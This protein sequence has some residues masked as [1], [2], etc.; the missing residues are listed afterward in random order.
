MA[1]QG[2][3]KME[4]FPVDGKGQGPP[5]EQEHSCQYADPLGG[6]GGQGRPGGPQM[7]YGHQQQVPGNVHDTGNGHRQKRGTGV[8][9]SPENGSQQVV[10]YNEQPAG[11]ADLDIVDCGQEGFFRSLEPSGQ[12]GGS[13][14]Q[15]HSEQKT[16]EEEQQDP[17][18]DGLSC[19]FRLPPADGFAY[20]DGYS[21][22]QTGDD[23]GQGVQEGAAG[24]HPGHISCASKLAYHQQIH[25]SIQRLEEKGSKDCYRKTE[26]GGENPALG[27]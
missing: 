11:P 25:P 27:K 1:D 14:N 20:Q 24:D 26:Q 18:A 16:Q 17:V 5:P 12:G 23:H 21:H 2:P 9:Q 7:E 13:G 10:A 3:G 4:K 8:T 15:A 19:L 6:R 22:G